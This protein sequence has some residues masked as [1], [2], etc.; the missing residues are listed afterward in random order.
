MYAYDIYE[1]IDR[2]DGE[3]FPAIFA[4]HGFAGDETSVA[5]I[6]E[7]MMDRYV[8]ISLRGDIDYGPGY[9]FFHM[10]AE[11]EPN[12][13][14][15]ER[16][17]AKLFRFIESVTKEYETIDPKQIF[18]AGFD[19]GGVMSVNLMLER[20]GF[21]KGA[22]ILSTRYLK[23]YEKKP[24]NLLLKEK[25]IFIGHG[26]EDH[27]FLV[28]EAEKTTR[29]FRTMCDHVELH[30]YFTSHDLNA[31]EEEELELWFDKHTGLLTR[32]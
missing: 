13:K 25:R 2:K 3:Q 7:V 5:G 18:L 28:E 32:S 14:E 22:A 26:V 24:K 27:V 4:L 9:A 8:I 23:S 11:G 6:L 10:A 1:P 15:I 20:G 29:L 16:K 17:T 30:T 31:Q 19:Q 12:E 21:F